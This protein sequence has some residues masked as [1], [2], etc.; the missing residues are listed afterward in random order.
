[1]SGWFVASVLGAVF[2]LVVVGLLVFVSRAVM[3]TARNAAELMEAL[4]VVQAQ[5]RV[6]ADLEAQSARTA[7]VADDATAALQARRRGER[8]ADGEG[9]GNGAG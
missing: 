8:V 1:M 9:T 6:L 4:E 7:L 3:R 5:T 2:A